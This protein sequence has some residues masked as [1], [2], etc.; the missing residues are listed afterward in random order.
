MG[1]VCKKMSFQMTFE[2]IDNR[3]LLVSRWSP[4]STVLG[5]VAERT[6]KNRKQLTEKSCV[7]ECSADADT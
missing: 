1:R 4:Q 2:S 6:A 7:A 5:Q 3:Q